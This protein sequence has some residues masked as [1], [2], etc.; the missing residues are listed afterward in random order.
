[1]IKSVKYKKGQ[2]VYSIAEGK[3][4]VIE[5]VHVNIQHY[6]EDREAHFVSYLMEEDKD[7]PVRFS[8][9]QANLTNVK[10]I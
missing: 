8:F 4:H 5:S 7:L 6:G 2:T 10:P 3:T 1:M 9:G